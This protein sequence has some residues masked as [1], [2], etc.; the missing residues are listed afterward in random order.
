VFKRL[1]LSL[2]LAILFL[3]S[4]SFV[5]LRSLAPTIFPVYFIY[6]VISVIAYIAFSQIDFDII[7]LFSRHFYLGS[8]F[9]LVIT[10]VIGRIT[11]GAIRWIALGPLTLQ[12]SEIVRPFLLV[13]FANFLIRDNLK[14][15]DFIQILIYFLIP[16]ILI[17]IQPS[18]GVA[19]VTAAGFGGVLLASKVKKSYFVYLLLFLLIS[20]PI[21]WHFL[22]VYQKARIVS[23][24]SP[25][26]DPQG[27][28]YNAIQAMISVGSGRFLGRGLGQGVETQL[29]FLPERQ[30]DFI[31][32]S[33][34]EE[35]G[36]VGAILVLVGIFL[37]LWRVVSFSELARGSAGRAY[38]IGLFSSLF[39]QVFL[40]VGMNMGLLPI[41]GVPL[42]LVSAG[43]SSLLATMIGLGIA[44]GVRRR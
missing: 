23:F 21:S 37:V 35:L 5:I 39:F 34:S 9:L 29:S 30:T 25:Y 3:L 17:L 10:L 19:L 13:F 11:R 1:D 40:H 26:Q 12:S 4:F 16:F 43:G 14:T 33:I 20:L 18:L 31:F 24:L 36:F 6:I 38:L 27:R 7:S 44:Q 8:L 41:T 32:A 22:A 42:P 2:T 15:K 28:G